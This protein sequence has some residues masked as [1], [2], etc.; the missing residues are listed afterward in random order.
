MKI[1]QRLVQGY[2]QCQ[3]RSVANSSLLME[4]QI[5]QINS[6]CEKLI[7]QN[8]PSFSRCPEALFVPCL[9]K[10]PLTPVT[11]QNRAASAIFSDVSNP[12]NGYTVFGNNCSDHCINCHTFFQ[13][14]LKPA[15]AWYCFTTACHRHA[16]W[17]N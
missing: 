15:A 10:A 1:M 8:T 7:Q 11:A 4:T 16:L 5:H 2:R 17:Q 9:T 14:N 12:G 6:S 3:T 13:Y